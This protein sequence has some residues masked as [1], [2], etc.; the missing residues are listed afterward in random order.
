MAAL[1]ISH[2]NV[3]NPDQFAKYVE[4]A[5]PAIRKHGGEFL[6]RGARFVQL[7]GNKRE[8]NVVVRFESIEAAE[9]CYNSPEYQEAVSHAR[10]ASERDLMVIEVTEP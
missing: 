8:R 5:G 6:A 1:W 9:A 10:G 7:E 2:I 4:L 3:T